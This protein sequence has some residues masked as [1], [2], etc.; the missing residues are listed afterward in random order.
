MS[1]YRWFTSVPIIIRFLLS[2][3][4]PVRLRLRVTSVYGIRWHPTLA[5]IS[6]YLE[7]I[8]R[9]FIN[10]HE[11]GMCICTLASSLPRIYFF[12]HLVLCLYILLKSILFIIRHRIR[13][14]KM[15]LLNHSQVHRIPTLRTATWKKLS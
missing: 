1:F 11:N 3:F 8:R 7:F 6:F 12:T 9:Q 10:N 15:L 13:L 4:F 2:A 14:T 5:L